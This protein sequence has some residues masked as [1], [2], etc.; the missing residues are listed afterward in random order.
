MVSL[1]NDLFTRLLSV[2]NSFLPPTT[3]TESQS[4]KQRLGKGNIQARLGRPVGAM[5][6]GGGAVGVRGA[7]RGMIRGGLRGRGRGGVLRGALALRGSQ[8]VGL[9]L[10]QVC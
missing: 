8:S 5:M 9:T 10:E 4:L 1:K 6:R 7:V 2:L 3:V